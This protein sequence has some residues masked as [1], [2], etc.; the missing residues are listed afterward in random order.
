[1]VEYDEIYFSYTEGINE[2]KHRKIEIYS[3]LDNLPLL[4]GKKC[5][6]LACGEGLYT[7]KLLE[8][9]ADS[10][11]GIDIS[12]EMIKIARQKSP[13]EIE[14]LVCNVTNI[15]KMDEYDL[16]SAAY[17]LCYASSINCLK[18][19]VQTIYQNLKKGGI[20]IGLTDNP[21][22]KVEDYKTTLKYGFWK[23]IQNHSKNNQMKDGDILM[24]NWFKDNKEKEIC[25]SVIYWYSR[26]TYEKIFLDCGFK[27]FTFFEMKYFENNE[28]LQDFINN[29][30]VV[31]IKVVK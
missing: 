13:I 9:G 2:S 10:V 8:F 28:Y 4:Y 31:G 20:F 12:R 30:P 6:D 29:S 17:L 1:M 18:K 5:L 15:I 26:Q 27:Q 3:F 19:Y 16:I 24:W 14:Y 11:I 23:T 25:Q 21:S 22:M 7:R